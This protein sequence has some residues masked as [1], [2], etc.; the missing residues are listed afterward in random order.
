MRC[1][2][3]HE[4]AS[5]SILKNMLYLLMVKA[6]IYDK[7]PW[8]RYPGWIPSFL[9]FFKIEYMD[10]LGKSNLGI[11]QVAR[12][13]TNICK[14]IITKSLSHKTICLKTWILKSDVFWVF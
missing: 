4:S 6:S 13:L 10:T 5:F 11:L 8:D 1:A 3:H 14:R 9:V 7:K 12:L 2:I